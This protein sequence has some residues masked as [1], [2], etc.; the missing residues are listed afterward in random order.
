VIEPTSKKAK[1]DEDLCIG[2]GICVNKCPYSAI[3]VLNLPDSWSDTLVHKYLTSGFQLF[4]LPS[5]KP[6]RILGILGKNGA[7]K[8]TALR[9]LTG[10]IV[11]NLG[12]ESGDE[13]AVITYFR[14]KE[15]QRYFTEVYAKRIRMAFKPQYIESLKSEEKLST[16]LAG[17]D[18]ELVMSF[19]LSD[20]L[21]RRMK[22]LSGGELQKAAI[23]H[24]A[25]QDAGAYFFDEPA[26]FLDVKERLQ[27]GRALARLAALGKYVVVVEHDLVVLDYLADY[28]TIIYGEAGAYGHVSNVY[29]ARSGINAYLLGHLASQNIRF[30]DSPV[31]FYKRSMPEMHERSEKLSWPGLEAR[32]SSGFRLSI[33]PGE[34]GR[35]EAIGVI[36]ENGIG[37][38][39]F[40]K[41]IYGHF[42]EKYVSGRPVGISYKPQTI[43][44]KFDGSVEELFRTYAKA[45]LDDRTFSTDVYESLRIPRLS[46]K[47]VSELSGGELQRVAIVFA[48]ASRADIYLLDEPSAYLDV[49]ERIAVSKAVR[50]TVESRNA[51]AFVIDHDLSLIDYISDGLVLIDGVAGKSA[52]AHAPA[53]LHDGLNTF[54]KQVG[55][56][57][58]RDKE[59]GRPR[60]NKAGSNLDREQK[61]SGEYFYQS[62]FEES[63]PSEEPSE[64]GAMIFSE[65]ES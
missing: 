27:L 35:G 7:G 10:E 6:G 12:E 40:V 36:G 31:R 28:L 29:S 65:N 45:A 52:T 48:L 42:Q 16:Y 19:G 21:S 13:R 61:S 49:E 25:S 51:V 24:T 50:R 41:K 63:K 1:I 2:C 56:T 30:R 15:L 3:A 17:S 47:L 9:I 34:I 55:I 46:Q 44:P 53:S 23:V 20:I 22:D 4:W 43:S 57:F 32:Y 60:A 59:T 37:K 8:T 11:P 33:L 39:T 58:R 64:D 54:L 38:T 62:S 14:G 26:S 5:P 18:S